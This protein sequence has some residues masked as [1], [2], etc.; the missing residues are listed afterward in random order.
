MFQDQVFEIRQVKFVSVSLKTCLKKGRKEGKREGRG[1]EGSG[2]RRKG[3]RGKA[4]TLERK[5]IKLSLSEDGIILSAG[6]MMESTKTNK[7]V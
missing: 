1:R 5:K 4:S 6:N 3:K 2:E 7:E